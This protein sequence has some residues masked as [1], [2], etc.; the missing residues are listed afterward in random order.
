LIHSAGFSAYLLAAVY[1]LVFG[2]LIYDVYLKWKIAESSSSEI[3]P[4]EISGAGIII[5]SQYLV[6]FNLGLFSLGLR[7]EQNPFSAW[8][9]PLL[10]L[11]GVLIWSRLPIRK[12]EAWSPLAGKGFSKLIKAAEAIAASLGEIV[13]L[14]T[15]L[16]EGDGGLMWT[17]LLGFMVFTL[18]RFGGG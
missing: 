9:A 13:H 11:I 8:M 15:R 4:L 14:M 7:F 17:L 3:T 10:M 1:G 6:S 12:L 2:K 16:F 18:A 5:L